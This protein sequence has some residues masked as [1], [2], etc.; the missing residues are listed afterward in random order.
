MSS[1]PH[2]TTV[3]V[4]QAIALAE[5]RTGVLVIGIIVLVGIVVAIGVVVIIL[6]QRD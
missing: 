3:S 5:N 2:A 1:Q 4:K 6:T